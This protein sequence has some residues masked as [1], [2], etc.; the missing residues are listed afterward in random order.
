MHH[1]SGVEALLLPPEVPR[2]I[3]RI[4]PADLR[5][6]DPTLS[7][8]HAR[9]LLSGNRVCVEDLGSTNGTW[10]GGRRIDKAEVEIGDELMLGKLLARVHA[11]GP[12]G[13]SLGI[14]GDE[15]FR[16][17]VDEEAARARQF[18]RP[19]S[20]LVVRVARERSPGEISSLTDHVRYWVE[21][22][23]AVL[24]PVDHLAS[25]GSD[26]A[27]ILLPETGA[28]EALK[29][30]RA[31]VAAARGADPRL[32]VGVASYPEAAGTVEVLIEKSRAA[33]NRA[34]AEQPVQ[35]EVRAP[36]LE[37]DALA[38][39]AIVAGPFMQELLETARRVA[40]SRV[41]V[42][43]HGETGTGKE[44][45]ARF[46]HEQGP[47]RA[48]RMVRVNCAAIP[49]H[50]VESTFFGHE[51][52]AFTGA[53]QQQKGIFE[54]ADGGT[55]FLDEL[56]ELP[57]A[58]QAA[59]LRVLETGSFF[60]VGSTR[61]IA[62][63]VRVVAA[64]HRD[65]AAMAQAGSFRADLYYRLD[66]VTL[67]I[68]PL[69]QR[70]D[71]IEPLARRFLRLANEANG[72]KVQGI[73]ASALGLLCAYSWPGNV[74][75]LKN[76]VERAVVVARGALITPDDL[77]VRVREAG[78]RKPEPVPTPPPA[79]SMSPPGDD[80]SALRARV[81]GY[82]AKLLREA[83]ESVGWNRAEAAKRLGMPL[84]TLSHKVKMLG[85]KKPET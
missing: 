82:E 14:E 56:G 57:H 80:A 71:E 5:I 64:T 69:R 61:E 18:Q 17:H 84:R 62:V 21:R 70:L 44:I 7:R 4:E 13:E 34:S 75:E 41:P 43:L 65:L 67:E 46:L 22:L 49:A 48:R 26:A 79:A 68:P 40:S 50:L 3:G 33:A 19:F 78:S 16:C 47:R 81:Q 73:E 72:R 77:P 20:L 53:V 10:V 25:Y 74:R 51:R 1:A 2:T 45:L 85:L 63:D 59:L 31:I 58:A 42:V 30:A 15:A 32:Y 35:A 36:W 83:L 23:R 52:G 39:D 60:R 54:E 28:E 66:T 24:R 6:N 8:V 9:F 38:D 12:S 55:V 27:Q 76:A 29:L 11:L 37:S